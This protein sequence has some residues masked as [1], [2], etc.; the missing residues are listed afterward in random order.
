M[1]LD[2]LFPKTCLACGKWKKY[3]CDNCRNSI[4]FITKDPC[5]YCW[6]INENGHIHQHCRRPNSYDGTLSAIYYNQIAKK[7]ITNIKYKLITDAFQEFLQ[8]LWQ[9]S[10]KKFLH[11]KETFP[12]CFIQ[13]IPLHKTR[14]SKR[15][16]NQAEII[17]KFFSNKLGYPIIHELVRV[18]NTNPQA[19]THNKIERSMNMRNAF[20]IQCRENIIGKNIILVDDVMTT[21]STT[22]EATQVLKK[23]SARSV[24]VFSLAHG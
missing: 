24:F 15:G 20:R 12:S 14:Q 13:P 9:T 10:G 5:I 6:K 17:A 8:F 7:I 1:F 18:K 4:E 23:A 21:G 11:F 19:K 22:K 2:I 3:I 16:F